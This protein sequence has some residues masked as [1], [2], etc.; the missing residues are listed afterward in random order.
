M[1]FQKKR[2]KEGNIVDEQNKQVNNIIVLI[3]E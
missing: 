1:G 2:Q 3:L